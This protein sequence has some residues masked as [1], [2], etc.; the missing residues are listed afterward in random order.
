MVSSFLVIHH[1]RSFLG[2]LLSIKEST[3]ITSGLIRLYFPDYSSWTE[4]SLAFFF[5]CSSLSFCIKC[6][7]ARQVTFINAEIVVESSRN[8]KKLTQRSLLSLW[9]ILVAPTCLRRDLGIGPR[10]SLSLTNNLRT[11][12]HYQNELVNARFVFSIWAN[13]KINLI[14]TPLHSSI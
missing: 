12:V 6:G 14:F 2:F 11:Y 1:E 8:F 10:R 9:F 4:T 7:C 5:F 13:F 3:W